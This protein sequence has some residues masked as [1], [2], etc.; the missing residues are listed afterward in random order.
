MLQ[1]NVYGW[2][3]RVKRGTY[4]LTAAGEQALNRFA[5]AIAVLDE[6]G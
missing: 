1:R 6:P 4:G 2:F 5:Q 3:D